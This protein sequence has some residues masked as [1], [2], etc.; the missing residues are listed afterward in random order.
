MAHIIQ[1]GRGKWMVRVFLGRDGSG[2]PQFH[3]R[4]ITGTKKDAQAWANDRE[5]ERDLLGGGA[6]RALELTVG[7]L[8]DDLVADYRINN[9]SF[10]WCEL[11][12]KMHLRPFFGSMPASRVGTD[13]IRAYVDSRRGKVLNGTINRELS[14]LRRAFNLAV[15]AD[16]PKV[17]RT[18]RIPKL[19]E[20]NVRQGF[21]E[22]AEYRALMA[23]LPESLRPV[24]AFGY[25]TG[26]RKGEILTLRWEQVDLLEGIVRLNAGE[27][28]NNESRIIPLTPDLLAML[29]MERVRSQAEYPGSP[30]VFTHD[31]GQPWRTFKTSWAAACQAAGLWDAAKQK[32]TRLFHDLRRSGVRNLVRAG[33]PEGVAQ[34]ISGHKTRAVFERYNVVSETDLKD[35][36]R[37]LQDYLTVKTIKDQQ[38]A[39]NCGSHTLVTQ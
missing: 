33:V 26:C 7:G 23:H 2:K 36:A 3:N 27:T 11:V 35:A 30:W 29:K 12:V 25:L 22:A 8:L 39:E 16:P 18:P 32:P 9:K 20:N 14:L 4:T 34:R 10:R 37:R 6:V 17:T 13:D 15:K 5:R 31:G 1:R 28:K 24:L 21:F 38:H 19:A